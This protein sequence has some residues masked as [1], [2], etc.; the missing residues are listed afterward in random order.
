MSNNITAIS[1][2]PSSHQK[3][4]KQVSLVLNFPIDTYH[5]QS[6]PEN[7]Q[8]RHLFILIDELSVNTLTRLKKIS[9]IVS[10]NTPLHIFIR[11]ISP[12][13]YK[14]L[15]AMFSHPVIIFQVNF[16]KHSLGQISK[17]LHSTSPSRAIWLPA[18]IKIICLVIIA[19]W[20]IFILGCLLLALTYNCTTK[21]L[22]TGNWTQTIYCSQTGIHAINFLN[23][24]TSFVVGL[25]QTIDLLGTTSSQLAASYTALFSSNSMLANLG[26]S[27]SPYLTKMF[28][29][30]ASIYYPDLVQVSNLSSQLL[31]TIDLLKSNPPPFFAPSPADLTELQNQ[32][33][34]LSLVLPEF[35]RIFSQNGTSHYA[36]VFQDPIQLTPTGGK[37]DLVALVTLS[38]GKIYDIEVRSPQ[39]IDSKINGQLQPPFGFP[40]E[41]IS[42]SH[43]TWESTPVQNAQHIAKTLEKVFNHPFS[44]VV[45]TNYNLFPELLKVTGPIAVGESGTLV[46]S[47]NIN[48]KIIAA[49]KNN[50]DQFP[51]Q[52]L[53]SIGSN[54][55]NFSDSKSAQSTYVLLTS[56]L[57]H[58]TLFVPL[59]DSNRFTQS[60]LTGQPNLP[61]CKTEACVTDL[62]QALDTNISKLPNENLVKKNLAIHVHI[63]NQ[64]IIIDTTTNYHFTKD[65]TGWP[66]GEYQNYFRM[67]TSSQNQ[68][69][70]FSVDNTQL[71][72]TITTLNTLHQ[73]G[74]RFS[75]VP[76]SATQLAFKQSRPVPDNSKFSYL[77]TVL[78]QP[79]NILPY[80]LN[81]SFPESWK[82]SASISPQVASAGQLKYNAVLLAPITYQF[83]LALTPQ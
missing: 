1:S 4:I 14:L 9:Q 37:I 41:S 33:A 43:I 62:I 63:N 61:P 24:T 51:S 55:V 50:D 26:Q 39:N 74:H 36:I 42:F 10:I 22:A 58:Q 76:Q 70:E 18:I 15:K 12:A 54:F 5:L 45:F 2:N 23:R 34:S 35:P 56:L 48:Q 72:P 53:K 73:Y 40:N 82:V 47:T 80:Q 69:T 65:V 52:L 79:G 46:D 30:N 17:L 3:F 71:F 77:L 64:Q 16:Q 6:F 19:P 7:F 49:Q 67:L 20:T 32:I 11:Q 57:S 81:F 66:K 8:T 13:D 25:D 60:G 27:L 68:L 31:Q 44:G 59:P 29:D 21:S 28:S 38:K 78:N 75:L 83:D